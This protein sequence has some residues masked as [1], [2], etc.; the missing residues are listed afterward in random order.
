M[1]QVDVAVVDSLQEQAGGKVAR[2]CV[3]VWDNSP[4]VWAGDIIPLFADLRT[5]GQGGL[6][7]QQE[8]HLVELGDIEH[9]D[10]RCVEKNACKLCVVCNV[11]ACENT[12]ER[13]K[14]GT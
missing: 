14:R 2:P 12:K 3:Q 8:H 1:A 9:S 10:G 5:S 6:I 13:Q 7:Q 4:D 11:K